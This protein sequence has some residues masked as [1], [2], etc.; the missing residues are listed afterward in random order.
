MLKI[1][2]KKDLQYYNY[3]KRAPSWHEKKEKK[4]EENKNKLL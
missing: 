4:E 2:I 3:N 1:I